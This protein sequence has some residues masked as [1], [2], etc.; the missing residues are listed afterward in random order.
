MSLY[1]VGLE[2]T[3]E[4]PDGPEA[5]VPKF[6]PWLWEKARVPK[7]TPW[8]REK[9]CVPK[10]TPWLREKDALSSPGNVL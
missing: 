7:L 4:P 8:L 5:W 10:L 9:A 3:P 1:K 2:R 6:T